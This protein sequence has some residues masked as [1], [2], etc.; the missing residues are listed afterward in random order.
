MPGWTNPVCIPEV[1][2][3]NQ[4]T[5]L[6]M[7]W[8]DK[9]GYLIVGGVSV[10]ILL[11]GIMIYA[12]LRHLV[13][14]EQQF[15]EVVNSHSVQAGLASNMIFTARERIILLNRIVNTNDAFARDD[16]FL[17]F[18][19]KGAEYIAAR[20]KL[21]QLQSQEERQ[22]FTSK[23][24]NALLPT[25]RL[26]YQVWQLSEHDQLNAARDLL[27]NKAIPQQENLI[28]F[29]QDYIQSQNAF[30]QT[31]LEKATEQIHRTIFY[32]LSGMI[33]AIIFSVSLALLLVVRFRNMSLRI[34][35]S[36]QE[37]QQANLEL[38]EKIRALNHSEEELRK[39]EARERIIRDS[40]M[41]AIISIDAYG[42][43]ETV[44]RATLELF[45]Y[46]DTELVGQNIS[47]LMPDTYAS[48]HDDYIR[49]YRDTGEE[50]IIG[51]ARNMQGKR[52]DGSLFPM[53]IAINKAKIDGRLVIVGV[54]QDITAQREAEE[55][56]LRS[57]NKLEDMVKRRTAELEIANA[58]LLQ[59]ASYDQ[60]T[61]LPNRT[62][63][64]EHIKLA[65][66]RARRKQDMLAILFMDLDGFKK[67]NDTLGH[68]KGDLLLQEI[69]KRLQHSIRATDTAARFGGD[70][71][72]VLLTEL[73]DKASIIHVTEEVLRIMSSAVDLDGQEVHIGVSIG[74]AIYPEDGQNMHE[75]INAADQ[76]M[77]HVKKTTKNTY[78]LAQNIATNSTTETTA[79]VPKA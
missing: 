40:T 32:L 12:G 25:V 62:L 1:K 54:M 16:L 43:I 75:L 9:T 50:R 46:S 64:Q 61:G 22:S 29:L 41:H 67:V 4:V 17:Q 72:V 71:F 15:T 58:R 60:L 73:N 38:K 34:S 47:M 2:T 63:L 48:E 44:N 55:A 36:S 26:L 65:L 8:F 5:T 57:H 39:S 10:I 37:L 35:A 11:L 31:S 45:G 28:A 21:I 70:E 3:T 78:A 59:M 13:Q 56:L 52:K 14:I 74:I 7:K 49:R 24:H 23:Q 19:N 18:R 20:D 27:V 33:L 30:S 79:H 66:A 76:A 68:E 51:T 6:Y 53:D 77:Y 42:N 69:A